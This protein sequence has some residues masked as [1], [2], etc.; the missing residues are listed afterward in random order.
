MTRILFKLTSKTTSQRY[1]ATD[2]DTGR[3]DRSLFGVDGV[4]SFFFC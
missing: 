4:V 3:R 1:L 2:G